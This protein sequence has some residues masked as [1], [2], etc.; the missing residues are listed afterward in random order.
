M[1]GKTIE[2]WIAEKELWRCEPFW[3]IK[4]ANSFTLDTAASQL[5]VFKAVGAVAQGGVCAALRIFPGGGWFPVGNKRRKGLRA[6]ERATVRG[7]GKPELQ[8]E[9]GDGKK[10]Q[11]PRLRLG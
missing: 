7:S 9:D 4:N 10:K 6:K 2:L 1:R 8:V 3:D 11:V 5:G